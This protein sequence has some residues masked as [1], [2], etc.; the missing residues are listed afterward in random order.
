[1]QCLDSHLYLTTAA[2]ATAALK[3]GLYCTSQDTDHS[4]DIFF[5][6]PETSASMFYRKNA[7]FSAKSRFFAKPLLLG[8][9]PP[10]AFFR[11]SFQ[12]G[13]FFALPSFLQTSWSAW[14]NKLIWLKLSSNKTITLAILLTLLSSR[15]REREPKPWL[16]LTSC[17]YEYPK[18]TALADC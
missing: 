7:D 12:N 13:D 10:I 16:P 15:E 18:Y 5:R 2:T 6:R 8:Q 3:P 11:E 17:T 14:S 9:K 1:M 4:Q